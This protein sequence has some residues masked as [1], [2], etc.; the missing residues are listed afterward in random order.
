MV[1]FICPYATSVVLERTPKKHDQGKMNGTR[2][3]R[4]GIV[5]PVQTQPREKPVAAPAVTQDDLIDDEPP[6]EIMPQVLSGERNGSIADIRG[7]VFAPVDP[8][9]SYGTTAPVNAKT[10]E[11]LT[12][13]AANWSVLLLGNINLSHRQTAIP[14][15]S[16]KLPPGSKR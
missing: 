15:Q 1:I 5:Y 13:Q 3:K 9:S 12:L 10:T 6:G 4:G 2:S 16:T 8:G 7:E 14:L 11:Y